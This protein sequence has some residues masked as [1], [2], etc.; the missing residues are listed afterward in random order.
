MTLTSLNLC[1]ALDQLVKRS[2]PPNEGDAGDQIDSPCARWGAESG[3]CFVGQL[4]QA[5]GHQFSGGRSSGRLFVQQVHNQRFQ[6]LVQ[7]RI[8]LAWRRRW[9]RDLLHQHH[10]RIFVNER[11]LTRRHLVKKD[12]QGVEVGPKVDRQ[13]LGLLRGHISHGAKGDPFLGQLD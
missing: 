3:S 2:F 8:Q 1:P 13:P 12:A 10:G 7:I 4:S 5:H 11:G 6:R 9:R